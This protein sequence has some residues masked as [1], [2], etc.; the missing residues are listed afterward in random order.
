[1]GG[2]GDDEEAK[3]KKTKKSEDKVDTL[4]DFDK[5]EKKQNENKM[6]PF[7]NGGHDKKEKKDKDG[8]SSDELDAF[9]NEIELESDEDTKDKITKKET[10]P[11]EIKNDLLGSRE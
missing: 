1:M 9:F 5:N 8:N 3:A 10:T 4:L 6:D 11:K 7:L 2:F